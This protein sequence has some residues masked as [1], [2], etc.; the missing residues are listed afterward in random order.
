[1]SQPVPLPA[2]ELA[3]IFFEAR[4]STELDRESLGIALVETLAAARARWPEIAIDEA[5]FTR[6]L[7]GAWTPEP[8]TLLPPF[9][10]DL[11]LARACL[12][13][14]DAAIRH[15]HV[16]MFARVDRVLARLGLTTTDA[17]D[18]KQD[19][20]AKLLL[21]GGDAKLALYQGTG[22]LSH[23]VASV[24][25]REALG[26][27]RRRRATESLGDDDLMDAADDPQLLAL[28][29]RHSA[30]FKQAFQAAVADLE[31]RDRAILRALIVD[32]HSVTE[33][34]AVYGI[35]RVTASRWV[36]EIRKALLSGT[37]RRLRTSLDLD[38]PS[39]DSA[40]RMIDSNLDMSLY[41]LLSDVA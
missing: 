41:R 22:P 5:D 24:A 20:R 10:V 23:W 1:M 27:I 18:V 29:S 35:H 38:E 2:S 19:I 4:E 26:L 21:G 16:E 17:D 12:Q 7:A 9:A 15:F 3:R 11:V 32:D 30:D 25:G 13:R 6:E 40:I 28:K 37:R 31:A 39:L 14:C 33:V 36:S 8:G 34:A